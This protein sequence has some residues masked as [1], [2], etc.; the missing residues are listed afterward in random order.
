MEFRH[1]K[2]Q[3]KWN[4]L[5]LYEEAFPEDRGAYAAYYYEWKSRDNE[6]LVLTDS[7]SDILKNNRDT[8]HCDNTEETDN[9]EFICAMLHLNPYQM[10]ICTESVILHYIVAVATALPYRRKGCMRRL[11]ME[12]FSW[13]YAKEEPFTYLMPADT[14]YYEPFGFRVIYDQKPVSF[15]DG[16]DEANCWAKEHFD[17]VTLRDE[18]Y[19]HFLEAEPES[20]QGDSVDIHDDSDEKSGTSETAYVNTVSTED[21]SGTIKNYEDNGWKPQIMCRIIHL[22]HLLECIR[23]ECSKKIYL[24]VEDPLITENS[25]WYCWM[26]DQKESYVTRPDTVPSDIIYDTV[27]SGGLRERNHIFTQNG[28]EVSSLRIGIEDLAK[29]LFGVASLHPSLCHV[30]VLGRICINEEV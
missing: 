13:L 9:Y 2:Q 26:V 11:M 4:S 5:P 20:C 23:A 14:A 17:V 29:Q 10:W 16:I 19:L 28:V 24:L 22:P 12:A 21:S 15:P 8:N 25:G 7:V 18:T 30:K 1:L 3:D 6:L 27:I